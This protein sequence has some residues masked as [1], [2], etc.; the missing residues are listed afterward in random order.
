MTLLIE[1]F[2]ESAEDEV[3]GH[4]RCAVVALEEAVMEVVVLVALEV[5]F[6]PAVRRGRRDQEMNAIPK[7]NE[8]RRLEVESGIMPYLN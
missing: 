7:E 6:E 3:K 8:G 2:A 4:P 1:F 5:I